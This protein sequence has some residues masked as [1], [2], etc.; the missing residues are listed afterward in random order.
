MREGAVQLLSDPLSAACWWMM[1]T[2]TNAWNS[3]L[4][5]PA[6]AGVVAAAGLFGLHPALFRRTSFCF[7]IERGG[8][9]GREGFRFRKQYLILDK[10]TPVST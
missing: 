8:R 5:F 6:A 2:T 10:D 3:L 7:E 4:V 9:G 1:T